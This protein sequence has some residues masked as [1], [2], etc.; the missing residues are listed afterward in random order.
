MTDS[1]VYKR[2]TPQQRVTAVTV[3]LSKHPEF[4][5]LSGVAC[6][7]SVSIT[8]SL[9]T[10]A[11]DGVDEMYNP[12]F[13]MSM[14]R[15]QLRYLKIH[16]TLH[17]ALRHCS[18]YKDYV[19]KEPQVSNIA[20]DYVVNGMIEEADPTFAF[21]DR[22]TEVP[23]LV[24]P[25]YKGW[26][27]V[28]V[29]KDLLDRAQDTD[30][31]DGDK[32]NEQQQQGEQQQGE[33]Q[34]GQS[35]QRR[36]KVILD[37]DGVPIGET[38]DEHQESQ[39]VEAV[40]A[41]IGRQIDDALH[42]GKIVQARLA[43]KDKVGGSLDGTMRKRDTNWREHLRDFLNEV[44]EGDEQSRFS[45]PNK[46]M[47]ASGFIMPSHFSEA[48]GEIIVACDTSGSMTG[49]YPTVFG[50]IARICDNVQPES[51]RVL[52]WEYAVVGDQQ[53]KPI[54]YP[55]ISKTL[56]P[57]GGGGTRL[58]AVAEYIEA[59]K[60]KPKA[61]IILTDGYIETDYRVPEVPV[62]FGV[63]DNDHF[64]GSRGKTVRI[65]S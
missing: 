31:C 36:K 53:F 38:L 16:E 43:G 2:M 62:L 30:D 59:K 41:E 10:A 25:K 13:V 1:T 40:E 65:Y 26:S 23:P 18:E 51:V 64:V 21:V 29:F 14:T 3:D 61:V 19:R 15:K 11:T 9:P 4:S 24:H 55:N 34:Q 12:D 60:Y 32:P 45:P 58:T 5:Q 7:G 54:D 49:L 48:S 22:P 8:T 46:R 39:R 63:C 47:L 35:Q 28:R 27:F 33:Q 52:W 6:L 42:Q 57:V 56:K 44:C 20:M 50:E 37:P 17:K